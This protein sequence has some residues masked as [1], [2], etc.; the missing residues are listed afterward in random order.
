MTISWTSPTY[1]GIYTVSVLGKVTNTF[2]LA[3]ATATF[4]LTVI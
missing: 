2:G 3:S 4:V 1:A